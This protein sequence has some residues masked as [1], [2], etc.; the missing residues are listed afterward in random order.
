MAPRSSDTTRRPLP[1][2]AGAGLCPDSA[3]RGEG[4]NPKSDNSRRLHT[5]RT[6]APVLKEGNH[7]GTRG[8]PVKRKR[9]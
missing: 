4:S 2:I 3:I 6:L 8:S 5:R 1:L 7:G 9:S